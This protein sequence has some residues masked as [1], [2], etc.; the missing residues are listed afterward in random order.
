MFLLFISETEWLD[1]QYVLN[2]KN[3]EKKIKIKLS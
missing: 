3:G 2:S 1:K